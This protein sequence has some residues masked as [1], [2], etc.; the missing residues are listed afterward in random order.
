MIGFCRDFVIPSGYTIDPTRFALLSQQEKMVVMAPDEK[1]SKLPEGTFI[2]GRC[3]S[4]SNEKLV[5]KFS[6]CREGKEQIQLCKECLR[7]NYWGILK[8][9]REEEGKQE[10]IS[11]ITK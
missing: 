1:N 7:E 11:D 2:T 4:C 10:N 9:F 3:R 8:G 5:Y 6:N